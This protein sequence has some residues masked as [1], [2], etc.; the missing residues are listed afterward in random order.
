MGALP[1]G[2]ARCRDSTCDSGPS[3]HQM[4]LSSYMVTCEAVPRRSSHIPCTAKRF[5]AWCRIA[6]LARSLGAC[7]GAGDTP[8]PAQVP[9]PPPESLL[10]SGI[11]ETTE[12]EVRVLKVQQPDVGEALQRILHAKPA[13]NGRHAQ[14]PH[15]FRS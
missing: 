4:M 13:F 3:A 9:Q 2:L 1:V 7:Q 6:A 12:G 8:C 15:N 11:L 10:Q 5:S 14:L